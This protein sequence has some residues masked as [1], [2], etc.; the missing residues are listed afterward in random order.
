MMGNRARPLW[1]AMVGIQLVASIGLIS[2]CDW[3]VRDTI[4]HIQQTRLQRQAASDAGET[5]HQIAVLEEE[6][7][8][9]EKNIAAQRA[10][11]MPTA[12]ELRILAAQ[13]GITPRKFERV[14]SSL[15]NQTGN[16]KYTIAL[17]GRPL[18]LVPFLHE[19]WSRFMLQYDQVA[20]QRTDDIGEYVTLTITC[21]VA[22]S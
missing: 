2:L 3:A 1:L 6:V 5:S 9:L 16:A 17:T 22:S 8:K 15:R 21:Q 12:D 13:Y 10:R 7:S 14:G 4:D 19:L 11:R 18:N 20:L